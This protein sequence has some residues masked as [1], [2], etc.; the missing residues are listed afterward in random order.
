MG[1][2]T[3]PNSGH[4]DVMLWKRIPY[5]LPLRGYWWIPSTKSFDIYF[6]GGQRLLNKQ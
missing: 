6:A 3:V 2:W 1:P 4:D 5:N